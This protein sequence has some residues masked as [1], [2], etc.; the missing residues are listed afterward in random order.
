MNGKKKS[1]GKRPDGTEKGSGYFGE[2]TMD[3]GEDVMTEL[4]IGVG[5]NGKQ[6]DIPAIV[7]TLSTKEI[8]HLKAGGAVTGT[9]VGKAV[10][11]ARK[12]IAQGKSPYRQ[13]NE[14]RTPRS[15]GASRG[16]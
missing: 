5:F 12:R 3:N 1:Y 10:G 4:T 9:I 8:D 15:R 7:P 6:M 16:Y 13:S 2:I 14:K 11:H